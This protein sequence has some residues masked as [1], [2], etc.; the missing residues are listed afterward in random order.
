LAIAFGCPLEDTAKRKDAL[1][2]V[3]VGILCTLAIRSARTQRVGE[4]AGLAN[5][6]DLPPLVD[7]ADTT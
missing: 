5:T 7:M 2:A 1:L 6:F 3:A 4:C